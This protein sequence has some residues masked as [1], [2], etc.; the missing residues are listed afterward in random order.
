MAS[1]DEFIELFVNLN[2]DDETARLAIK[3]SW[4]SF[5][6]GEIGLPKKIVFITLINWVVI[7]LLEEMNKDYFHNM[8]MDLWSKNMNF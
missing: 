5:K 4:L 8:D 3:L 7:L 6:N 1:Y 2:D